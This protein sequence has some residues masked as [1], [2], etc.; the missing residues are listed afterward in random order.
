MHVLFLGKEKARQNQKMLL[1]IQNFLFCVF[2][3]IASEIQIVLETTKRKAFWMVS[4]KRK[5]N[6]CN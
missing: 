6:N 3:T 1:D 5:R 2:Q 4:K